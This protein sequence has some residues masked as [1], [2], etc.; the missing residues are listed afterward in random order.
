[1]ARLPIQILARLMAGPIPRAEIAAAVGGKGGV[2]A[3]LSEHAS[4]LRPPQ[5]V[6]R[7]FGTRS[8]DLEYRF[9]PARRGEAPGQIVA[10]PR[11]MIAD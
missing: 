3:I 11:D 10:P 4:Q 9:R 5:V 8:R 6:E 7:S 2:A 1:M